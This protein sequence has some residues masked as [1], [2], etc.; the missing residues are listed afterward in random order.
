M[1][2]AN[3]HSSSRFIWPITRNIQQSS[4]LAH[5][6]CW[7]VLGILALIC[8]AVFRTLSKK[9]QPQIGSLSSLRR[10]CR[11]NNRRRSVIATTE[12]TCRWTL[13]RT[14]RSRLIIRYPPSKIHNEDKFTTQIKWPQQEACHHKTNWARDKATTNKL[15]TKTNCVHNSPTTRTSGPRE[16][17]DFKNKVAMRTS[18]PLW[19]RADNEAWQL[20]DLTS[21]PREAVDHEYQIDQTNWPRRQA[22][23]SLR[24]AGWNLVSEWPCHLY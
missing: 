24:R 8:F 13:G 23:R 21:W 19:E 4:F 7:Q 11:P 14:R 5:S 16:E 12:A 18:S 1:S 9:V 10:Y 20:T 2:T 15:T 3:G 6:C 17:R 22:N